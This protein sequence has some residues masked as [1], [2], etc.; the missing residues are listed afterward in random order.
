VTV[1]DRLSLLLNLK[2]PALLGIL[3]L[4]QNI[5]ST[6]GAGQHIMGI[7]KRLVILKVQTEMTRS[8]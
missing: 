8:V 2:F 3:Y 5:G 7:C 1:K 6:P 4:V